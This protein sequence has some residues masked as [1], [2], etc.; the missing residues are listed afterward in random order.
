MVEDPGA[1]DAVVAAERAGHV[2]RRLPGV[3][4]DLG[5]LDVHGVPAQVDHGHLARVARARRGLLEEQ[6]H[7]VAGQHRG[8]GVASAPAPAGA[9]QSSGVEVVD[10]EQVGHGRSTPPPW[11]RFPAGPG[12]R[13]ARQHLAEDAERRADLV[14]AHQQRRRHPDGVGAH[15]VHQQPA[16]QCAGRSLLGHRLAPVAPPAAAR[17]RAPTPPR[18]ARP[19]RR[20]GA[21]RPVGPGR[22]RPRPPSRPAS[23]AP[24]P[25]PAAGPPKVEPWSPGPKAAATSARAQQAPTGMPLPS[26]LAIVT[27]SGSSPWAWKANQ[28]PVRPSPVWTS[29]SISSA[30]RSVHSARTRAEVVRARDHDAALTLDAARAARRPRCRDR[31][32]CRARRRRRR[33]RGR[34]PRAGA[35]TAPASRAARWP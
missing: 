6:R 21:P 3:E 12:P 11:P 8:A 7:A 29:S 17:R 18:A 35:G 2:L 24:R 32:P 28:W 16:L 31:A 14:V 9:S 25:A 4:A 19:A 30:L 34:S 20:P 15:R 1:Q 27:T 22:T 5:A 10:V 33:G 23:P 13:P 26:A